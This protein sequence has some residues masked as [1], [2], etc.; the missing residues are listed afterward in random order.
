MN[1]MATTGIKWYGESY[2]REIR[3]ELNRRLDRVGELLVRDVRK[4]IS[5]P[6]PPH[7]HKGQFPHRMTGELRDS[8]SYTTDKRS[9][10]L[11]L[12]A[13][14]DHAEYVEEIRPF[15]KRTF[16]ARRS[17][18]RQIMLAAGIDRGHFERS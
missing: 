9:L 15:L 8:V 6:A 13:T 10:T 17:K 7:S 1:S 4:N 14:A 2:K 3:N 18:V 5:T 16:W 12:H 11:R